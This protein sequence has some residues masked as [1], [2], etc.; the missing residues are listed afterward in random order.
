L[1]QFHQQFTSSFYGHILL[2]K[3][4]ESQIVSGEKLCKKPLCKK[5][6]RKMLVKLIPG[7]AD[8][9]LDHDDAGGLEV[10]LDHGNVA[11]EGVVGLAGGGQDVSPCQSASKLSRA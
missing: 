11:V 9:V 7:H 8:V 6:A 3:K 10:D 1:I 5:S 2:P 4:L